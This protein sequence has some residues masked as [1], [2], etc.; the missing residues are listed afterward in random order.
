VLS[1]YPNKLYLY[2]HGQCALEKVGKQGLEKLVEMTEEALGNAEYPLRDPE[3]DASYACYNMT[4]AP[5]AFDFLVWLVY[6]EMRRRKADAPGP[7]KVGFWLGRDPSLALA[8]AKRVQW[9]EHVFRPALALIGAV[10]DQRAVCGWR[11]D[12]Y[13]IGAIV[14]RARDGDEVP[15]FGLE[16]GHKMTSSYEPGAVTITL[17]EADHWPHRNSNIPAWLRFAHDL[18]W[19][20]HNVVFI[21]DTAK[22]MEPIGDFET[23]PLASFDLQ[24]RMARYQSAKANLFVSNGPVTLGVFSDRP[25]LQFVPVEDESSG[26]AANRP[27]FWERANGVKVGNQYPWSGPAQ[28]LVWERDTYQSIHAAWEQIEE[29]L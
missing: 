23:D 6:A 24:M 25:W 28:R 20:G 7:L 29:L 1:A 2:R 17:R 3:L 22:A 16:C 9:L 21:R 13:T 27:S 14:D 8:D 4:T 12:R 11:E 5:L 19:E 18:R 26:Y 10:E 15:R